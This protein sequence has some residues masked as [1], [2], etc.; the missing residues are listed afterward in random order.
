MRTANGADQNYNRRRQKRTTWSS[1][2]QTKIRTQTKKDYIVP[3]TSEPSMPGVLCRKR[4]RRDSSRARQTRWYRTCPPAP[5]SARD[6]RKS[7]QTSRHRKYRSG[8]TCV[9]GAGEHGL[10]PAPNCKEYAF[11]GHGAGLDQRE[12]MAVSI[13]TMDN[14]QSEEDVMRYNQ[15]N[16]LY[17]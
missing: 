10:G 14:D 5:S 4:A 15:N 1:M 2:T 9:N 16:A 12:S 7:S 17:I 11:V 8:V 6:V 3:L 13:G